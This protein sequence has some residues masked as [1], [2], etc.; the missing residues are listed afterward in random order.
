EPWWKIVHTKSHRPSAMTTAHLTKRIHAI[1]TQIEPYVSCIQFKL[2]VCSIYF[3]PLRPISGVSQHR[4]LLA[5][6]FVPSHQLSIIFISKQTLQTWYYW[7]IPHD[8]RRNSLPGTLR[9]DISRIIF[10]NLVTQYTA[11]GTCI[12]ILVLASVED[13]VVGACMY[14]LHFQSQRANKLFGFIRCGRQ[15]II[16]RKHFFNKFE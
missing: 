12:Q 1:R 6:L 10:S 8:F 11:Y 7:R 15:F 5:F 2:R 16:L 4:V 14:L 9:L 13:A 3:S